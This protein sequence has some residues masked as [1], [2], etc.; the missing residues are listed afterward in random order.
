MATDVSECIRVKI[1]S[2]LLP[3]PTD[4]SGKLW[5]G[6]GDGHACSGCDQPITQAQ[7]EYELDLP[8]RETLRFH[9]QCFDAWLTECHRG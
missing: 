6:K 5:V 4:P 7:T 8:T 9:K 1:A 2:G 3:T